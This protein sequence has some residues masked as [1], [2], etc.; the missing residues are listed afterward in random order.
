M[1]SRIFIVETSK[2]ACLPTDGS[3]DIVPEFGDKAV[4]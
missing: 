2:L 4:L 3:R 1:N